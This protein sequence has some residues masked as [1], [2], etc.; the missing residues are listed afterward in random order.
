M[1]YSI[2]YWSMLQL[3]SG[4]DIL[5]KKARLFVRDKTFQPSLRCVDNWHT[6]FKE[7]KDT[8][9]LNFLAYLD[10]CTQRKSF[11]PNFLENIIRGWKLSAKAKPSSL[12][13]PELQWRIIYFKLV[14]SVPGND[15]SCR[16]IPER[17]QV[18]QV[19]YS[20]NRSCRRIDQAPIL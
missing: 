16:K 1:F 9:S 5:Y 17:R 15:G 2:D 18:W 3:F 4:T 13:C 8:N 20:R 14:S 7:R 11:R 19:G 10:I 6:C 12:L